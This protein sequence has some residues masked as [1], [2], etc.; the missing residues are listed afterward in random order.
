VK[1]KLDENIGRRGYDFLKEAGHDV[2]TVV[3]QR[4]GG[5]EDERIFSVCAGEGRVLVTLD[6][7][8]G[9]ILRFPPQNAAGIVILELGPKASL[10]AIL[11]R[12]RD[13]VALAETEPVAGS[14]WIVS[15]GQGGIHDGR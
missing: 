10:F 2:M 3:E 13:F 8:F 14:L 6:H 5:A 15:P 9:Q 4:L 12:L 7:D 11:A 1:L